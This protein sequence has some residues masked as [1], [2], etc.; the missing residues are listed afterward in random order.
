[1]NQEVKGSTP[2]PVGHEHADI[3]ALLLKIQQQ[4]LFLERKV[5]TLINQ[6]GQS[7]QRPPARSPERFSPRPE[8]FGDRDRGEKK[9]F[10]KAFQPFEKK[11]GDKKFGNKFGS[12]KPNFDKKKKSF[13]PR[14]RP[15]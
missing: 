4:M 2:P 3:M 14:E 12:D 10:T 11:Y 6:S 9:P 15:R 8:K 1:M 7:Y 5:D 13:V